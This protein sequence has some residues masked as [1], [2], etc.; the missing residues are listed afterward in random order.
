LIGLILGG[1]L[2]SGITALAVSDNGGRPVPASR[3]GPGRGFEPGPG[4]RGGPNF[5][6]PNFGGPNFGNHGKGG[7]PSPTPQP[8]TSS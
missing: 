3:F 5:G 8:S 1:L 7:A 4:F 2:G 6:G